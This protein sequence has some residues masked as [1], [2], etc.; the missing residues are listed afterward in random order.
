MAPARVILI[1]HAQAESNLNG[2][3]SHLPDPDITLTGE[4]QCSYLKTS[5]GGIAADTT[6]VSP[7]LRTL[8]T[9]VLGVPNRG[10]VRV[11]PQLQETGNVPS[12]TPRPLESNR[13]RLLDRFADIDLKSWDWSMTSSDRHGHAW[14]TKRGEYAYEE[15]TL[16]NRAQWV[17]QYLKTLD[18]TIIVVSHGAFIRYLLNLGV[19]VEQ[20]T[21][22]G[23]YFNNCEARAYKLNDQ[24]LVDETMLHTGGNSP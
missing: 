3:Q 16:K 23:Y 5:M 1:R 17:R 22:P 20:E 8:Q 9:M 21:S 18:G 12:D 13:D 2:G 10:A 7:L 4:R 19:D 15:A 6:L 14:R 24:R 11:V